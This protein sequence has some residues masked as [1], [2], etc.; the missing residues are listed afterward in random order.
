MPNKIPILIGA[1]RSGQEDTINEQT[2]EQHSGL[3]QLDTDL[4]NSEAVKK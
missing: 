4:K 2:L 1:H 3:R